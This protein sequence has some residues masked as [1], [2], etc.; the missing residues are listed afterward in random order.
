MTLN[1]RAEATQKVVLKFRDKPFDWRTT[2]TCIHL[3]RAQ[4]AA[5]GHSLPVVPHFRSALGA[6]KALKAAGADSLPELLDRFFPR[7][8]AAA[9]IVGDLVT[10][11]GEADFDSI[12]VHS[13]GQKILGWHRGVSGMVPIEASEFTGAWRL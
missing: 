12:T 7:I 10:I 9:A 2:A 13:G 1:E 11:Q 3:A 5:L 4:A 6:R 8:P